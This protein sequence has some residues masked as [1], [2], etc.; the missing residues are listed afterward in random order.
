MVLSASGWEDD[1]M[2]LEEFR[3]KLNM[4][5]DGTRARLMVC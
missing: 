5:M 1:W 4:S 3:R 2:L